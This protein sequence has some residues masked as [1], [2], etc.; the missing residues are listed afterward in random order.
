ME[1]SKK[2]PAIEKAKVALFTK[3]GLIIS[4]DCTFTAIKIDKKAVFDIT[5]IKP[6]PRKPTKPRE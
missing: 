4:G 2:H 1:K 3:S 6:M 5:L